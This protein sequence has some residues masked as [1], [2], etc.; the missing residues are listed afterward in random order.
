MVI[1]DDLL[2][3]GD[4]FQQHD[5]GQ[6]VEPL[7]GSYLDILVSR[8]VNRANVL[9][10][11]DPH[12]N[13]NV[14]TY[15]EVAN[16]ISQCSLADS[17]D[18]GPIVKTLSDIVTG[19]LY[20]TRNVVL[21]LIDELTEELNQ[22]VNRY[23]NLNSLALTINED[24]KFL[25]FEEPTLADT[26]MHH[27]DKNYIGVKTVR[28]HGETSITDLE[29]LIS[30]GGDSFDTFI[31]EYI[32][33]NSLGEKLYDVYSRVFLKGEKDNELVNVVNANDYIE[34]IL[35]MVLGWALLRN[36]Q[37]NI[38]MSYDD[39]KYQ[40]TLI[41]KQC[42]KT[43]RNALDDYKR[44][45]NHKRLIL[46]YPPKNIEYDFHRTDLAV[47]HINSRVY[48][49]FI[50]QGGSAEVIYGA[51]LTDRKVTVDDLLA[52]K[53]EYLRNYHKAVRYGKLTNSN[54]L[55]AGIKENLEFLSLNMSAKIVDANENNDGSVFNGNLEI[56]AA[57]LR[58]KVDEFIRT[59]SINDAEDVYRLARRFICDIYFAESEVGRILDTIDHIDPNG[60]M[61]MDDVGIIA[62]VDILVDN[63]LAQ[64]CVCNS[65]RP[66]HETH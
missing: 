60:E 11:Q 43:L 17:L 59:I 63:L 16:L 52:N 28:V 54:Q 15:E 56:H 39:Y 33:V 58:T 38:P 29:N 45:I 42:A 55:L 8:I 1:V 50:E 51:Y 61:D 21:P 40:M 22:T 37:D 53:E 35:C 64:V 65:I 26:I 4:L 31:S 9:N 30:N 25:I 27:G 24:K 48:D 20:V 66:S 5:A 2:A 34:N 41:S 47:I 10:A 14:K 19:N 12:N 62:C 3:V 49:E 57:K 32:R 23:R 6:P 46:V 44:A 13:T 36:V 18:E 7:P